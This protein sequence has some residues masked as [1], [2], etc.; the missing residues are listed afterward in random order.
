MNAIKILIVEDELLIAKNLARKLEKLGYEIVDIA[1]SGNRAI[2]NA[3]SM[4]PNLI[5]MDIAIKGDIDGIET[6]AKIYQQ[7]DL[8]IIYT[9]A[10]ADDNTIQRAEETGSYGY[11][12]KPF[13]DR[14]LH[15]T[16]KMALSKHREATTFKKYLIEAE[17]MKE[18]TS[19]YL[20]M[21]FHDLRLP[22]TNIQVSSDLLKHY[23]LKAD[24]QQ[25]SKYFQQINLAVSNINQLLDGV[26]TLCQA[27]SGT[28]H[29]VPTPIAIE[30]FCRSLLE[31][32]QSVVAGK[33]QLN[34]QFQ[35]QASQV[36][37]DE[38]LLRHILLNLLSNAIK[39]SPNGGKIDLKVVSEGENIIFEIKDRGIGIPAEDRDAIFQQFGRASN[40]NSIRGTGLGLWFVKQLVDL[41]CGQIYVDSIVE[42]GT[43]FTVVLPIAQPF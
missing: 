35:G 4:Q 1:S 13:Q 27:E 16:I 28:L 5:L 30:K 10:Y 29:I 12:I 8:P 21:A 20:S 26:L 2:Q 9:T 34:F 31:T 43:R 15:A 38:N 3:I 18:K 32:L 25:Q 40:V 39:Y 37:L 33:H 11:L 23:H 14:D 41:Q 24:E 19:N 22:L 7:L 17:A 36:N 42:M 6:A